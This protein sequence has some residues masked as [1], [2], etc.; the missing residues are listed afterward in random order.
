MPGFPSLPDS[1]YAVLIGATPKYL[2]DDFVERRA[3]DPVPTFALSPE[4]VAFMTDNPP[5]A[6]DNHTAIVQAPTMMPRGKP[7][8]PDPRPRRISH[9][10]LHAAHAAR[11]A[12]AA[13]PDATESPLGLAAAQIRPAQDF[14]FAV[15]CSAC[16]AP[17]ATACP[18]RRRQNRREDLQTGPYALCKPI[19][20]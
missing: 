16:S 20:P 14:G 8:R 19:R 18:G 4:R 15:R 9:Q 6:A 17:A 2:T 11:A 10:P 7:V 12:T 1:F 5:R 3:G 13:E